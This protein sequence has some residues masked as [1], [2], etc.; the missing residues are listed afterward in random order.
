MDEIFV[1][2][3]YYEGVSGAFAIAK[4]MAT[5]NNSIC[6][7]ST[8]FPVLAK[9]FDKHPRF[10]NYHFNSEKDVDKIYRIKRGI[11]KQHLA[12]SLLEDKG[13]DD[14]IIK[15]AKKMY[16]KLRSSTTSSN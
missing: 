6:L 3:N 5:F 1:S 12:I 4:K 9:V 10:E 2:T 15:D 8:H 14:D 16:N 7:I 11:S 13:F